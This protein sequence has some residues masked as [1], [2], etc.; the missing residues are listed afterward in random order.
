MAKATDC[1]SVSLSLVGSN[2][3]FF[4]ILNKIFL[5]KNPINPVLFFKK[6][7]KKKIQYFNIYNYNIFIKKNL[8]SYKLMKI[9][10][11]FLKLKKKNIS[12]LFIYLFIYYYYFN[13]LFFDFNYLILNYKYYYLNF[14]FKKNS[15][16][17][18]LLNFKKRNFFFLY[19]GFFKKYFENKKSIK[20]NKIIKLL[21]LKFIKKIIFLLKINNFLFIFN[22]NIISIN[23]ILIIFYK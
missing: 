1:K 14:N 23:E 17:L 19:L 4:N 2:P 11:F 12:L 21:I 6:N 15:F 5:K 10:F 13:L 18:N 16:F 20:K 8:I 3:T 9:F 22:K 7:S